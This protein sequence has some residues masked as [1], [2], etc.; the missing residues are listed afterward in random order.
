MP[1][2][3]VADGIPDLV[4]PTVVVVALLRGQLVGAVTGFGG[5]PPARADLPG[6]HARR[7]RPALPD[8]GRLVRPLLRARGV[9][10]RSLAPLVLSVAAAF[11]VQLGY[12]VFQL[13]L[14]YK[15][16]ASEF[17]GAVLLPTLAL[18]ALLSP[19]VLL[20][21][22][23][24]LG[25]PRVVEP[26][27]CDHVSPQPRRGPRGAGRPVGRRLGAPLTPRTAV[28]IA[29][30]GAIAM[31]LL[32]LLLVRLWFL[33]V[34]S[35][36]EY[37][38][39]AESNRLR[40]VITEAP[41]GNILDR[42]GDVL[43][44]NRP[45]EERGR[46]PPRP[47]RLAAGGGALAARPQARQPAP[48]RADQEGERRRQPPA[49]ARR[50]G[51]ERRPEALSTTSPSG[52]AQF[53]GVGLEQTLP[54]HLP[55]GR[56]RGPRPRARWGRSARTRSTTTGSR[57]YAGER[58]RGQGGIEQEY[59]QFLKGTPG[60]DR[61]G[62]RRVG[63]ARR[64]ARW[65]ASRAPSPGHDIQLSIDGPT[66]RAMQDA[67]RE[68]VIARAAPPAP[69]GWRST[70]RTGEVL[71]MASYPTYDPSVF[72]DGNARSRSTAST[73]APTPRAE[74]GHRG[75]LPVRLHLQADHRLGGARGRLHH[76][77]RADRLALR[78]HPLQAG[79]PELQ[80]HR[81]RRRHLPHGARGLERHLLLPA[82]RP[83]L[84][85]RRGHRPAAGR[86]AR[87][88]GSGGTPGSTCPGEHARARA[89]PRRGSGSNYAG[90]AF[91]DLDRDW[92][93]GDTI[94]L[95]VG[96]GY[97]LV[98]PAPDGRGLRGRSPTAARCSRPT[99]ARARAGPQRARACR[100]S[101]RGGP[102]HQPEHARRPPGG[103]HGRASTRPPT[104][105]TAPPPACSAACPRARQGGRQ[106]RHG[107]AGA[108]ARTTPG[109]SATR[110][111][112]NPKI[113]VAIVIE[114]GGT[115]ANAAAPAAC[116][117]FAAYLK[118]DAGL[119]RRRPRHGG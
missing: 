35:G 78:G 34:I 119:L 52:A 95:A 64:A 3:N 65:S 108:A 81:P 15:M 33:Q 102:T 59:E 57:G 115:G 14:G 101:R 51:R 16:P 29:I 89:R 9:D 19:P 61:G 23:R 31:S 60:R 86:G 68:E 2:V 27:G 117:T 82:R 46:A 25:A 76:A 113:V 55:A 98:T 1:Y 37:A 26:Y 13:L 54:A 17:V 48:G 73:R 80:E 8:R 40:T 72:V 28:R 58:D 91:N 24:L 75:P 87:T 97:L 4:A 49:G 5:G 39:A 88:S 70:R 106:D 105:R 53:P 96:Q 69:P 94:Q 21:G 109:S 99:L 6:R 112:N 85:R 30:L 41:R 18:T 114:R 66:Q 50:P 83:L 47:H 38:A 43:V 71:A 111:F 67:L 84:P 10:Q 56:A 62:G 77:R 79:L 32:G 116:Q 110:P 45:G 92:K 63:R 36:E 107:R 93:P 74:P 103:D 90:P 11:F 100:S 118:F 7:A 20:V 22:R 42:N 12:L 44:A 104:A